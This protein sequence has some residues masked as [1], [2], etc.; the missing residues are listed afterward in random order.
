[1]YNLSLRG[2]DNE[3]ISELWSNSMV[4]YSHKMRKGTGRVPKFRMRQGQLDKGGSIMENNY[5]YF[6]LFILSGKKTDKN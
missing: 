4:I 1:M 6:E 3:T 2:N 5:F